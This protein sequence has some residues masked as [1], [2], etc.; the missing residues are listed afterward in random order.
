MLPAALI[1]LIIAL[2]IFWQAA[3]QRK[4][5]GLPGGQVIYADTRAWG[6]VEKP[7][8][9][10][11]LGLTGKP[12]Y[13]VKKGQQIIPVEVKSS[14]VK[15][16]P[17]DS[18]IYQLAAYCYLIERETGV[19]P[20]Y[21]I[22]HYPNRTFRVDY[23]PEMEDAFLELVTEMRYQERRTVVN[24]SHELPPRCTRCGFEENCNQSLAG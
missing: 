4:S 17:Y 19:R 12:D 14:R 18:H 11:L 2:L 15:D 6:P 13:L 7:F 10:P 20:G 1:T 8:Y 22:L 21:G 24:R 16:S 9:D 5:A 3:R 23:T